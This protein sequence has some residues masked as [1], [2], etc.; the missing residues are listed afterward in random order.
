[1]RLLLPLLLLNLAGCSLMELGLNWQSDSFSLNSTMSYDDDD[2]WRLGLFSRFSIGFDANTDEYFLSKRSLANSGT[3]MVRVFLDSNNN[4]IQDDGE[5]G[6][7][8]VKVKGVQ[9]YRRA[10]TNENG[11]AILKGMPANRTTDIVIEPGSISEP[12]LVAANDGFSITPRAGFVEYMEIPLNNS[13]EL[14]GTVY[15][16]DE[17]G[18]SEVQPFATVKLLDKQGKQ[19]AQTQAA[20][21]GYYLFTDLRPG[22]YKAVIDDEFKQRKSLKDTQQVVVKL[23]AQGEVVMGVDFELKEKTQTPAYIANA[24]GFSSLPIMK[25][26]YQLIKRH[27]NEQSKR[28]AFYIKDEKQKRYILAVAY[29]E[30]AQE[31]LEQVCAELKVKGL[32][33]Q[34]QTQLISH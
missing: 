2:N 4:N 34:V 12:F 16:Q 8:G 30:S 11:L 28:D 27:L 26:Y 7:E 21:D 31:E 22:E 3:L 23:P 17:Q 14:E 9:N 10:V 29:A 18:S 6:I 33:C 25:A 19:V 13:S 20:Y 32:N 1:M 5:K 24:G 15:K